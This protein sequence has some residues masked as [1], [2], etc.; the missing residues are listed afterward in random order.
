V[1]KYENAMKMFDCLELDPLSQKMHNQGG[2]SSSALP[3]PTYPAK[4]KSNTFH[5]IFR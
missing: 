2:T 3:L 1:V 5:R 4:K